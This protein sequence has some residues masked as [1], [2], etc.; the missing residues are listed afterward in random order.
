MLLS[1]TNKMD[2]NYQSSLNKSFLIIARIH[3]AVITRLYRSKHPCLAVHVHPRSQVNQPPN[4]SWA[5][6]GNS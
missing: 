4:P 6:H 2:D 3:Q 1:L 5:E